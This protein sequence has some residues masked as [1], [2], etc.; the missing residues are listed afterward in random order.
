M[1]HMKTQWCA[2][3]LINCDKLL[4]FGIQGL[5]FG[6]VWGCGCI[7]LENAPEKMPHNF[8]QGEHLCNYVL[9]LSEDFVS[10]RVKLLRMAF[11]IAVEEV[12][13]ISRHYSVDFSCLK[14]NSCTR[15]PR[16]KNLFR[17]YNFV[18]LFA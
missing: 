9:S 15:N 6:L 18:H 16:L 17:R 10:F 12:I 3:V 7:I 8:Q 2:Q 13:K 1:T 5:G 11:L 14:L 4:S